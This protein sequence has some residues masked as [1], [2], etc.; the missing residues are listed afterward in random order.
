MTN[1]NIG[2]HCTLDSD[3]YIGTGASLIPKINIHSNITVGLASV[4]ISNLTK[5][6]SYF[7]NPA[8]LIS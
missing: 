5:E 8:K 4:V 2:G 1:V 7:G 6:G 3:V